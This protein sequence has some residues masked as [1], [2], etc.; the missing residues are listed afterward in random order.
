[1][2]CRGCRS[3]CSWRGRLGRIW[4]C[5][6]NS[7]QSRHGQVLRSRRYHVV[8]NWYWRFQGRVLRSGYVS[9][10]QVKI[11]YILGRYPLVNASRRNWLNGL[12]P[13]ATTDRPET[14]ETTSSSSSPTASTSST[15]KATMPP[16]GCVHGEYYPH[17]EDCR[18][19]YHC[20]NNQLYAEECAI[21]TYWDTSNHF[22]DWEHRVDCCNGQRPCPSK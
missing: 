14:S 8:G 6:L 16:G 2:A 11:L 21:G 18:L 7:L 4:Q 9:F 15:T 22:C 10:C 20:S 19:Y 13:G 1:M 17:P 5:R 3:I 12:G